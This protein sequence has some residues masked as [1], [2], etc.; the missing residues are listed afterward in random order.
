[1]NASAFF[2][3]NVALHLLSDDVRKADKAESLLKAGGAVSMQVL[4]ETASVGLRKLRLPRADLEELLAAIRAHCR[5]QPLDEATFDLGWGLA[6][7]HGFSVYD[8]MIVAAA[9]Q[10]G[11][12]TLYSEDLHDGLRVEKRLVVRN[13]F[14]L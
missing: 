12:D 3:T 8:A 6:Q 1:M 9:L 4:N 7:R 10:S 11:A 2:D 13:P 14:K 5:V